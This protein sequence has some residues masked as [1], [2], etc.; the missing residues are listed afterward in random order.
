MQVE[1]IKHALWKLTEERIFIATSDS[2]LEIEAKDYQSLKNGYVELG[3]L[4][5]VRDKAYIVPISRKD[6]RKAEEAAE[7]LENQGFS[8]DLPFYVIYIYIEVWSSS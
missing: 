7:L 4:S 8:K 2:A 5:D 1:R 6:K 3:C